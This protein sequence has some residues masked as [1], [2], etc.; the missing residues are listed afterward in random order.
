MTP[1]ATSPGVAANGASPPI[2]SGLAGRRFCR[3]LAA[4]CLALAPLLALHR[5][6]QAD[7]SATPAAFCNGRAELALVY[8]SLGF[9][10][11]REPHTADPGEAFIPGQGGWMRNW[12]ETRAYAALSWRLVDADW[13]VFAPGLHIGQ[14]VG[15]FEAKNASIG[16]YET[17]ETRPALLWGPSARLVLRPGP[18]PGPYLSA[19]YA[20]FLAQADEASEDVA[21]ATG[22]APNP[23]NRD[24]R[25][26][27]TS[28]EA[29]LSLGYDFGPLAVAAGAA[30]TAFRL[31]KRIVSHAA[32]TGVAGAA[33]AAMLARN[34]SPATYGYTPNT[35]VTPILSVTWRP[36]RSLSLDLV[37]RP[38]A[39]MDV[40]AG[41][42]CRF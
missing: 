33:L 15:R 32:N 31:D 21:S 6:A 9:R 12:N 41:L 38:G 13:I 2:R 29:A 5:P 16:F 40:S 36:A 22:T 23:A 7:P 11:M 39:V 25:F 28:H 37:L 24:A 4:A 20:L 1:V 35:P 42:A 14:A 26:S 30:V 3:A 10:D 8:R 17:W 18:G 27:W 19:G 34:A